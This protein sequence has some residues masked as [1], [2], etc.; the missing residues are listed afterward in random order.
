MPLVVAMFVK[1]SRWRV[2][3]PSTYLELLCCRMELIQWQV[4]SGVGESLLAH[5]LKSTTSGAADAT[6]PPVAA[7]AAKTSAP[8]TATATKALRRRSLYAGRLEA[9]AL[10]VGADVLGLR[11]LTCDRSVDPKIRA[12]E[13]AKR[14]SSSRRRDRRRAGRLKGWFP[15]DPGR[16]SKLPITQPLP[17]ELLKPQEN[18]HPYGYRMSSSIWGTWLSA[19]QGAGGHRLGLA[20]RCRLPRIC[21]FSCE[22]AC[23]PSSRVLRMDEPKGAPVY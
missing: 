1:I 7:K 15:A 8:R 14:R 17:L 20:D 16:S 4:P 23:A 18:P 13:A 22:F 19:G 6:P 10:P 5:C 9:G 11:P 3:M 21:A 12:S 2:D